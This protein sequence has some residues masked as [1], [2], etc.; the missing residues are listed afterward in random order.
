M[1]LFGFSLFLQFTIGVVL[2]FYLFILIDFRGGVNLLPLKFFFII[3]H[4]HTQHVQLHDKHH[5][6]NQNN[7]DYVCQRFWSFETSA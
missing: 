6:V 3:K 7:C 2:L 4:T 5:Q 1:A